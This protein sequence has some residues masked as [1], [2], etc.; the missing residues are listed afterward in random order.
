[1]IISKIKP[2]Y[3]SSFRQQSLPMGWVGDYYPEF[4]SGEHF[5]GAD[6][7]VNSGYYSYEFVC[8]SIPVIY[9]ESLELLESLEGNFE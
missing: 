4:N 7:S 9:P 6:I 3:L 1:M 8:D 2:G 5:L